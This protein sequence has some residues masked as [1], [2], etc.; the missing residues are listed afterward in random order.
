[1]SAANAVVT[2]FRSGPMAS[3]EAVSLTPPFNS[4][5][6]P[7]RGPP[8]EKVSLRDRFRAFDVLLR[9]INV[10][11]YAACFRRLA[12]FAIVARLQP[13]NDWIVFQDCCAASI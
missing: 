9:V 11:V 7:G 10:A 2:P 8:F 12:I 5:P 4:G 3:N 6:H 13:V 1:M